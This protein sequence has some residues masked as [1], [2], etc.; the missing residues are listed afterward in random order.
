MKPFLPWLAT[1]GGGGRQFRLAHELLHDHFAGRP[2]ESIAASSRVFPRRMQADL[3]RALQST[4]LNRAR[5]TVGI[6]CTFQHE[7]L[8][9]SVLLEQAATR[10][11]SRR[12]NTKMSTS[13]RRNRSAASST[14][15]S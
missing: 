13:A 4:C 1:K 10:N 8:R 15:W 3:Q 5:K 14:P 9:F 11:R 2:P 6:H 12:C 7:S